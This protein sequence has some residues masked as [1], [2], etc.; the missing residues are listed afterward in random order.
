MFV[1][2]IHPGGLGRT[3]RPVKLVFSPPPNAR[4]FDTNGLDG[5]VVEQDTNQIGR[6]AYLAARCDLAGSFC[7]DETS[8]PTWIATIIEVDGSGTFTV[9]YWLPAKWACPS[10]PQC[11]LPAQS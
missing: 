3:R 5:K 2:P 4:T 7:G 11:V 8:T 10:E 1:A 9:K 6:P